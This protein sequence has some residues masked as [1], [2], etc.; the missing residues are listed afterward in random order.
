ME[1]LNV[2]Y[3]FNMHAVNIDEQSNIKFQVCST[4]DVGCKVWTPLFIMVWFEALT[5]T[6]L[7]HGMLI[8]SSNLNASEGVK[9]WSGSKTA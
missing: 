5:V 2:E 6:V 1:T 8:V 3:A 7:Y 4:P 9:Y